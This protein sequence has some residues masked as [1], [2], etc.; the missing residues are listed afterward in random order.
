[1]LWALFLIMIMFYVRNI[2]MKAFALWVLIRLAI[3]FNPNTFNQFIMVM[4]FVF[5]YQSIK[6]KLELQHYRLILNTICI[7]GIIQVLM[8]IAQCFNW[9]LVLYPKG[10]FHKPLTIQNFSIENKYLGGFIINLKQGFQSYKHYI[11][12]FFGNTGDASIFLALVFPAFFRKKW[13]WFIPLIL[14]GLLLTRALSGIFASFIAI[15]YFIVFAVK[16][17]RYKLAILFS[18]FCVWIYQFIGTTKALFSFSGRLPVW[19]EIWQ[20]MITQRPIIGCG[21]GQFQVDFPAIQ[22]AI[23]SPM[24]YESAPRG[25]RW[26]WSLAHNEYIQ[27]WAELGTIGMVILAGYIVYTLNNG[28]KARS[29]TQKIL[30]AGI[31]SGMAV[32]VVNFPMHLTIGLLILV[33]LAMFEKIDERLKTI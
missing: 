33:Y 28:R 23:N 9:W 16:K 30:F 2:W 24:L 7:I 8:Q 6:N 18:L 20:Y 25:H 4:L 5:F 22:K 14:I 32:S 3:T 1:M 11:T 29:H 17:Y 12:G 19:K 27:L 21:L 10:Y 31:L 15:L 13:R 26:Y